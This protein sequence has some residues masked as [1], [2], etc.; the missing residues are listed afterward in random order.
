MLG[1][2]AFDDEFLRHKC[3]SNGVPVVCFTRR[4]GVNYKETLINTFLPFF[5]M[6][7]SN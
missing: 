2:D 5:K 1:G 4:I 6:F 3:V 7:M